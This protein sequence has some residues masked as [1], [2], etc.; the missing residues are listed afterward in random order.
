MSE[1][2]A[3]V[4]EALREAAG[5]KDAAPAAGPTASDAASA[6]LT[7][8][9]LAERLGVSRAQVWKHVE[10]LRRRGYEIEG[11][12]G[13]GYRLVSVPD[14]LYPEEI[15]AGLAT[16]WLARRIEWLDSTDSTNRVAHD[17][18]RAGAE[19]GTT[20]VAEA[21]TAGRGRQGRSFFSPPYLNL[22]T[23]V[24]LRP[25]LTLAEAPTAILAAGIAVAESVAAEAGDAA[26]VELKW[27]N[28]VLMRG[29]KASGILMELVA[30][31]TRVGYLVLGIGVNLNVPRERFPAE[32]AASATSLRSE[33]GRSVERAAFARR[34]YGTLEDV[35]ELHAAHG[36]A[37]LRPRFDR[38]YR[39]A[40]RR[41]T[42]AELGGAGF[43]GV[44]LE[45]DTDG[46]LR[47]QRDDG[48]VV[49]VLAGD[50]TLTHGAG[51]PA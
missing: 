16:R 43:P 23:S 3:C 8:A 10:A 50:V 28:D 21:Q 38:F 14:R 9:A 5:S 7:G 46:A 15:A 48:A 17:L 34:L 33:L 32:F 37:A 6:R 51:S 1:G 47:V 31:A 4:L 45:P 26:A 25:S 18:A 41:I 19:H 30:E 40:G 44:A 13:G 42:V 39:M 20:V 35:L 29:R 27:P 49:R 11:A 12:P 24:V 36:F 2:A 22:Y